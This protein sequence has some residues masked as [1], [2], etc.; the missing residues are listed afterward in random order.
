MSSD[1][2]QLGSG[3]DGTAT[4]TDRRRPS[5]ATLSFEPDPRHLRE[6]LADVE[7]ALEPMDSRHRRTV[8][9]LVGEVVARL[10]THC[11]GMAIQLDLEIKRD[12]VRVDIRHRGDDPC[13]F[14]NALDDT[15]FSD[16][17]TG[18]GRD[19]RGSGGAWF[20]IATPPQTA[21]T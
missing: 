10:I 2:T 16:L 18:W 11:P 4:A 15:V 3:G 7:G 19:R 21:G 13:D 17:T 6:L 1:P 20:E 5:V 8:R 14:W 9:L 12:S